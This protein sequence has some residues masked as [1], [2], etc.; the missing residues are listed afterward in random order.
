MSLAQLIANARAHELCLEPGQRAL[1]S[2]LVIP[3]VTAI[4][5]RLGALRSEFDAEVAPQVA[6]ARAQGRVALYGEVHWTRY[7]IGFCRHIRD[8][9]FARMLRDPLFAALIREGVVVKPVFI[10]LRGCYF[11]NAL[12]IGNYYFDVAN[13]TVFTEKAK[14]DWAPIEQ[15]DYENIDSWSRFIAVARNYLRI[16]VYPNFVFPVAF[17]AAP[18]FALRPNGRLDLL[19]AQHQIAIKDLADGMRRTRELLQDDALMAPVLPDCY[20]RLLREKFS[21]NIFENFPLE[22]A[23]ASRQ[24][25]LDHV[26]PEFAGL[27]RQPPD[28]AYRTVQ[29]YFPLIEKSARL[30]REK[31]LR[32]STAE[33]EVLR[34]QGVIPTDPNAPAAWSAE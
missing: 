22:Y 29:H 7:P 13:D 28:Q 33:I 14:L 17:P 25:I 6:A 27:G 3:Q 9:V 32:P 20:Q 10:F 11:Q 26:L 18:F 16:A 5:E 23:P 12:Q 1:T 24:H 8:A 19:I 21:A 31:D 4:L 34:R 2:R 15:L 30:L